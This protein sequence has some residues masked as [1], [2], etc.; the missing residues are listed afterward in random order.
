MLHNEWQWIILD[1]VYQ[2]MFKLIILSQI[3]LFL[4][5]QSPKYVEHGVKLNGQNTAELYTRLR[6]CS[7]SVEFEKI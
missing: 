5:I 2:I 3:D 4:Y 6:I 7:K 1:G